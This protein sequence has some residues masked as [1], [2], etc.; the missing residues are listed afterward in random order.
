MQSGT[1]F[2]L[3]ASDVPANESE[4]K[5]RFL[6]ESNA[7]T[8]H[9]LMQRLKREHFSVTPEQAARASLEQEARTFAEIDVSDLLFLEVFAGTARLSKAVRDLGFQAMPI[10]KSAKRSSQIHICIYNL[11]LPEDVQQLLEFITMNK[12]RIAWLHFAPACGTAS[13]ARERRL[14]R[15]EEQGFEVA[16]PLRSEQFP[17]GFPTLQGVDKI[18]VEQ[19]NLVYANTA[20]IIRHA[21]SFN[22]QCSI[23]NPSNSLF[24][25]IPVIVR[26]MRDFPGYNV[27]FDNCCHG[28][29][30]KKA[31]RWWSLHGWFQ[32]LAV[33][34]DGNHFHES[35]KP[36]KQHGKLVYPTAEEAAYPIL[37]CERLGQ[38]L[39][40]KSLEF[41]AM[42]AETLP[43]QVSVKPMHRF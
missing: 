6:D 35:W 22:I 33:L 25:V 43:Q 40:D 29:L 12:D 20:M 26:L 41:G 21:A 4:S 15:L 30:R 27:V 3:E 14:P 9:Q 7:S 1:Q 28:G 31:S 36:V 17:L 24:W 13:R 11:A 10:D 19:A 16:K 5:K 2:H 39:L 32:S 23:E 42:Q 18:R 38:I 34:C 37:L 8:S